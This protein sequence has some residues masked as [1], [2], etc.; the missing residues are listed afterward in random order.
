MIVF[1]RGPWVPT[2]FKQ[3]GIKYFQETFGGRSK[4]ERWFRELKDR[5]SRFHN[6]I[7]MEEITTAIALTHNTLL[8]TKTEERVLP[9]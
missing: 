7:S 8:K 5:T 6:N 2:G 1:D 4:V 9:S 3:L